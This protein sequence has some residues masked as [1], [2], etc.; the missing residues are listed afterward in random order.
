MR[1]RSA[2]KRKIQ[3]DPTYN[4][5][6]LGKFIN[7]MMLDGKKAK[8][9]NMVYSALQQLEKKFNDET[10]KLFYKSLDNI[11]P[12]VIVKPRRI[13]GATYQVPLEVTK[14]KGYSI[15]MHWLRDV[16]RNQKDK[17]TAQKLFEELAN[18][19]NNEGAII[20]KRNDAHRMAAANRAFAHFKF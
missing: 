14:E 18:A 2:E 5:A 11:R 20:K 12:R 15:A 13:G 6:I 3:P 1:R 8:S 19:Y 17:P 10:L 4:S 16:V 7:I 9:T